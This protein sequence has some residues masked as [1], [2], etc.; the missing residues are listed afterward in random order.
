MSQTSVNYHHPH[1]LP[2]CSLSRYD[3]NCLQTLHTLRMY[4]IITVQKNFFFH[5]EKLT[6]RDS[7]VENAN[8]WFKF[9]YNV[10]FVLLSWQKIGSAGCQSLYKALAMIWSEQD[11][12]TNILFDIF[13]ALVQ[14][15]LYCIVLYCIVLYCIVRVATKMLQKSTHW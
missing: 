6:F 15:P 10:P 8:L 5:C 9:F 7:N 12:N 3:I 1:S 14:N 2:V 11:F 4:C 13:K